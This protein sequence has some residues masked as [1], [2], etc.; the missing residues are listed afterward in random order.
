MKP[1]LSNRSLRVGLGAVAFAALTLAG[2]SNNPFSD[3]GPSPRVAD[4]A[5]VSIGSP[6]KYACN[7]KV[8][9]SFDLADIRDGRPLRPKPQ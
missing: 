7:N 2:C 1:R 5:I 4:C 3:Y 9:T 8:Y 6:T